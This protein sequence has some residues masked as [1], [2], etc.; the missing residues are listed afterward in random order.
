MTKISSKKNN[1]YIPSAKET[2]IQIVKFTLFSISAGLIETLSFTL[3]DRLTTWKYWPCYL[4]ALILSI[5]WNFTLNRE[6]TFKSANNVPVAM[7]QIL[8]FYLI[9]TP[10]STI[11][12][13]FFTEIKGVN[14][15][16]VLFITMGFNLILEYMYDR[17]IVYRK[18]MNTNKRA[19]NERRKQ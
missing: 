10:L 2:K 11:A 19:N 8:F 7:M 3:L 6:F 13:N 12:G 18:S 16:L 14:N 17:Y 15:Y 4:F 1:F 5:I 9:F